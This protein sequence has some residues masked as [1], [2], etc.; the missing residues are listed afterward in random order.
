[1]RSLATGIPQL[2]F[3]SLSDGSRI[4]VSPQWID[5]TG[6]NLDQS[7][8]YGWMDAIHP[9]DRE[10][11]QVAWADAGQHGE[12]RVDVG[13]GGLE[14][15]MGEHHL[16]EGRVVRQHVPLEEGP[17]AGRL[18]PGDRGRRLVRASE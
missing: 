3:R 10:A 2:V 15:A 7:L 4:W 6:L 13:L 1:M 8:G 17:R 11:T 16:L 9:D 12:E 5:F 18:A 14:A